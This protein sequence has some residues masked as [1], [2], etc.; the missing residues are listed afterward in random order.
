MISIDGGRALVGEWAAEGDPPWRYRRQPQSAR[1]VGHRPPDGFEAPDRSGHPDQQS[2]PSPWPART[3]ASAGA[4]A[5]AAAAYSTRSAI[6]A[7]AFVV[8]DQPVQ[9]GPRRM[10]AL[11]MAGPVAG[12]RPSDLRRTGAGRRGSRGRRARC[13]SSSTVPASRRS[14][15]RRSE[16]VLPAQIRE[17]HAGRGAGHWM[18]R[19][20]KRRRQD[21]N[22]S[23]GHLAHAGDD[24]HETGRPRARSRC[25][26][27]TLRCR[28]CGPRGSSGAPEPW[29]SAY[30]AIANESRQLTSPASSVG[31][32][33]RPVRAPRR[34][35]SHGSSSTGTYSR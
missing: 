6:G 32:L 15:R 11:A 16:P 21:L 22:G 13:A 2:P 25:G 12:P 33:T 17:R 34:H 30:S 10:D 1:L 26:R 3:S 23:A 20:R 24:A 27:S 19:R 8:E 18:E 9:R 7:E 28:N 35:R 14:P 5:P 31:V 29:R 4:R